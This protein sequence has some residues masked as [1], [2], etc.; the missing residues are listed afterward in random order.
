MTPVPNTRREVRRVLLFTLVLNVI[1]AAAKIIIGLVSGALSITADGF[2]SLIDGSSNVVALVANRLAERPPDSD[3]QYGHRRFETIAALAIGGFLLVTAWEITSSALDRLGGS[4]EPPILSPLTFVVML[5]TLAINL[6]VT[7]YEG[8]EGRRLNSE[9]LTA[10]ATHTRTDVFVSVS[11]LVSMAIVVL[12]KWAW[13][14]TA[15]ALVIVA[16]ILRAAWSVLG[17]AAGVLVDK[18][19]YS[20]EE[21]T[22]WVGKVP[23]VKKVIRARSRGPLDAAYVDID[24]LVA[25]EMTADHTA[26]LAS[27]IRAHL[28]S[29]ISGLAEVEVHFVP[30]E[31]DDPDFVLLARARADA[32]GLGTHEVRLRDG[33]TGHVLELHVEVP[34]DQT[35]AEAHQRVSELEREL[36]QAAPVL[37]EVVTHIE[38]VLRPP[39]VPLREEATAAVMIQAHAS[40]LLQEEFPHAGWHHF[41]VYPSASGFTMTLH[42]ALPSQI[43]VE[44]AHLVAE[45]AET[46]LR[47]K[48]PQLERVTIHTEP[49]EG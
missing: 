8:R 10:D 40:S 14:D 4:G 39:V 49:P 34:P 18:A 27:A 23:D 41:D 26:A 6:F 29:H 21:L 17:Q 13:A 48:I 37:T 36:R 5:G 42:V 3:H 35:L 22:T 45:S 19:P 25:R 9:L 44:A 43:S 1:V 32:L 46:F 20:P 38:P 2:H 28:E 24:V 12:F 16:L 15:A 7:I 30:A 33:Q 47:A 31:T 11:V